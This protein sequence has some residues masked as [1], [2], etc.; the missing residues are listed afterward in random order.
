MCVCVCVC[1][2]AALAA[3]CPDTCRHC[4]D[5]LPPTCLLRNDSACCAY[6][7]RSCR[8]RRM[9]VVRALPQY[10][11]MRRSTVQ[12]PTPQ[13]DK[14][15]DNAPVSTCEAPLRVIREQAAIGS[16]QALILP[17]TVVTIQVFR[18]CNVETKIV[19][20][21]FLRTILNRIHIYQQGAVAIDAQLVAPRRQ[22]WRNQLPGKR[23][24]CSIAAD[25]C[26]RTSSR[27][28]PTV[29]ITSSPITV[30]N[31]GE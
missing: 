15:S 25:E 2:S 30:S 24:L 5:T 13:L 28:P 19:A 7:T 14:V 3:L 18:Y 10:L 1:V 11:H 9:L 29:R 16:V 12:R 6:S 8:T 4:S 23:L 31:H 20:G 17:P 21:R 26:P 22:L 27:P